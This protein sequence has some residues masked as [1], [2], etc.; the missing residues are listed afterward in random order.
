REVAPEH[1]DT[2]ARAARRVLP[3]KAAFEAVD[4]ESPNREQP[5]DCEQNDGAD[6]D[7]QARASRACRQ[8]HRARKRKKKQKSG[9]QEKEADGLRENEEHQRFFFQSS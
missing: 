4:E 8:Q 3:R 7:A 9:G 2:V 1:D 6:E 5:G